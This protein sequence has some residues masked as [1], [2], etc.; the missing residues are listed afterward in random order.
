MFVIDI[1]GHLTLQR[2]FQV[3]KMKPSER[4]RMAGIMAR[5]VRSY[6]RKRLRVQRDL[7]GKLWEKRKVGRQKMLRGM[8]KKMR[9]RSDSR[10]AEVRFTDAVTAKIGYAHQYGVPE[11]WSAVKA[12]KVYGKPDYSAP[13]TR[14]QA[15]ALKQEGY[16]VRVVGGKKKKPTIKWMLENLTQGQAGLILRIMRDDLNPKKNWVIELPERSFLGVTEK[17]IDAL[18]NTVFDET[19]RRLKRA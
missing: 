17:E 19:L 4:R 2:Q 7:Q 11:R 18:A 10:G 13:C 8:S 12:E 15:R 14:R 1:S 5:K 6:S 3:L 16:K 9:T